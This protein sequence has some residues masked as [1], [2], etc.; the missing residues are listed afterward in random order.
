MKTFIWWLL[1]GIFLAHLGA[2]AQNP[3]PAKPQTGSI[4]LQNAT[5]HIGNGQLIEN[6]SIRFD[7]GLITEIGAGVAA[8]GEII[9]LKGMHVYPG[10][11]LPHSILGLVE[12]NA[13]RATV[14]FRE[15]DE[16]NPNVRSL[17]AY[18]TDSEIIYATRSNGVLLVQTTPRG[19]LIP[20][21]SSVMHLDGWNWEDAVHTPDDGV[22]L[23]WI[24]MFRG[25]SWWSDSPSSTRIDKRQEKL[26]ALRQ[27]FAEAKAYG[28]T[29]SHSEKN[30]KFEAMRPIFEGKKNLYLYADRAREILEGISFAKEMGIAKIVLVGGAEA[31]NVADFLVE[32]NIPVILE[33]I[34]RLPSLPEDDVFLPYQL[35]ALLK[36]KGVLVA[37]AYD[38]TEPMGSRNLPFLAGT[39]AAYGLSPEEALMTV[40]L[41]TAKI[42]GIDQTVGSL[43]VGKHATL[44]VSQGDLLDMRTN[45]VT[46]AFIQGKK[47]DLDNKQK[48]LYEI[49]KEKYNLK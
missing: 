9:D 2:I 24:E 46:H 39:A 22:H 14:D 41:N 45:D 30:L 21:S 43:E 23:N 44:V 36:A 18:N 26:A 1:P 20:G 16:F 33:R 25:P 5:L 4:T 48:R 28:Q 35:P 49:F 8:Q 42:L 6:G 11:I 27:F 3:V 10:L 40:T 15:V 32:N 13:V 12:V 17:I 47:I 37:L 19:S 7:N 38:D 29:A 34:H 31:L